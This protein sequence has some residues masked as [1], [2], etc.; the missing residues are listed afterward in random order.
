[1]RIS[2]CMTNN[3]RRMWWVACASAL[4]LGSTGCLVGGYSSRGGAFIW[5]SGFGLI[6]VIVLAVL[7][8]RR[9]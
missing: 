2:G 7:L 5:P 9:R 4:S 8:L 1:M 6:V 3:M